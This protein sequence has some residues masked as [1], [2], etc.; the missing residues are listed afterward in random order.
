MRFTIPGTKNREIRF[1]L[2][3]DRAILII[4]MGIALI[5]WLLVK[6]SQNYRSEK[7]VD[8]SF[9]IPEGKTFTQAPPND[10]SVQVEGTGWDLMFDYF[11]QKRVKLEYDMSNSDRLNLNLGL[12]RTDILNRLSS[13]DL[14]VTEL[15]YDNI[16]LVLENDTSKVVPIRLQSR[17][18]YSPEYHLREEVNLRPDS[19]QISGPV[20]LVRNIDYWK[21]DSLILDELNAPQEIMVRLT[22]AGREIQ[23]Q[24]EEVN[25]SIAVEQY[26]ERSL[27]VPLTILNAPDSIKV[28]PEV[29][30]VSCIL[31]LSNYNLLVSD[32]FQLVLDLEEVPVSE[33]KNTAPINLVAQ[34]SFVKRVNF[35]PKSAEFFILR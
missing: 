18:S 22:P 9:I 26:T 23:L 10:L 14:K 32:S 27:F 28:F 4:C 7:Q 3:E 29:V 6:L 11:S 12:L 34:P 1:E 33:S 17:F 13:N 21:T 30:R 24:Y 5:F 19:V 31:G 20:S 2:Q 25:A 15:N 16:N 35:S 8:L